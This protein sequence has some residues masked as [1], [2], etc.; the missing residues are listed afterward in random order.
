VTSPVLVVARNTFREVGRD[1]MLHLLGALVVGFVLFSW[2][3]GWLNPEEDDQARTLI[4]FGLAGVNVFGLLMAVLMGSSLLRREMER[5]TLYTVLSREV[6]RSQ[7]VAGKYLGLLAVFASGLCIVALVMI[8]YFSVFGAVNGFPLLAAIYGNL[9][10]IAVLTAASVLLGSFTTPALAAIGT[11]S[12][13][14]V[15]HKTETLLEYL[16]LSRNESLSLPLKVLYYGFPNLTDFNY[17]LAASYG[18]PVAPGILGAA[19]LY[20][21]VWVALLLGLASAAFR[22]REL[23]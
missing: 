16:G 12:L 8:L 6:T 20:A 1:R 7:F 14:M 13:Y 5:R 11:V 3:L 19:T 21:A 22:R 15:G 10:E 9:L 23:P 17:R 4:D 18:D 2:V